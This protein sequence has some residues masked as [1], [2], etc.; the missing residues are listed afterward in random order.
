MIL[1]ISI[2]ASVAACSSGPASAREANFTFALDWLRYR[3]DAEAITRL[4]ES[5]RD[6]D[7]PRLDPTPAEKRRGKRANYS[8]VCRRLVERAGDLGLLIE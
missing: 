1:V 8:T 5:T 6:V 4:Y 7:D 2:R 3:R